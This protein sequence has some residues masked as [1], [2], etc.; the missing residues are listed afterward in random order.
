MNNQE[1]E[2]PKTDEEVMEF[3]TKNYREVTAQSLIGAYGIFRQYKGMS[4]EGAYTATLDF[5]IK[6]F[7]HAIEKNSIGQGGV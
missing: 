7:T 4:V 1:F 6:A 3:F 2:K 5:A